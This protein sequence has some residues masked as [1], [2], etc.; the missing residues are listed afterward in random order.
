LYANSYLSESK[1]YVP[2][3]FTSVVSCYFIE[4]VFKNAAKK[5]TGTN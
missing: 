4:N 5:Y 1:S 2:I 3:V